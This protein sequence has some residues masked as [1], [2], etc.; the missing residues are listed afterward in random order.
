MAKPK[1]PRMGL[2]RFLDSPSQRPTFTIS[3]PA[4][5]VPRIFVRW[6]RKPVVAS[7]AKTTVTPAVMP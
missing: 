6:G 7:K 2:Q 3:N 1:R 5:A 4:Q